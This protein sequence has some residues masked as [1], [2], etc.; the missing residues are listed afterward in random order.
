MFLRFIVSPV[1]I[2]LLLGTVWPVPHRYVYKIADFNPEIQD[3]KGK[4]KAA[5]FL[6]YSRC[7][8]KSH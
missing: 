6:K 8:R 2:I 7:G 5:I 4:I 3:Q 1:P